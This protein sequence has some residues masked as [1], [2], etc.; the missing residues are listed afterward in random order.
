MPSL[1]AARAKSDSGAVIQ[2]LAHHAKTMI[3]TAMM[4][5]EAMEPVDHAPPPML[6]PPSED[7][8]VLARWEAVRPT[9]RVRIVRVWMESGSSFMPISF[10]RL[11]NRSV[12]A[13]TRPGEPRKVTGRRD[14]VTISY[15]HGRQRVTGRPHP[16]ND[17]Q[18]PSNGGCH[19]QDD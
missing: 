10:E 14:S 18:R 1:S 13:A 17:V 2:L 8:A 3:A 11:P 9:S 15:T 12:A 5:V 19:D 6:Q 4:S 16:S 7:S